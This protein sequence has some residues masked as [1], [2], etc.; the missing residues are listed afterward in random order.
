MGQRLT[1]RIHICAICGRTPDDGEHMWWMGSETWCK[2]C[3]EEEQEN[4]NEEAQ[5][6]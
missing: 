2:E 5:K 6:T 3:C 1:Q 4:A